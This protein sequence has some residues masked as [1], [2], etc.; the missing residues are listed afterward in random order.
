MNNL[1]VLLDVPFSVKLLSYNCNGDDE[2]E[3]VFLL[4]ALSLLSCEDEEGKVL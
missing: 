4:T 2:S 3:S 1:V